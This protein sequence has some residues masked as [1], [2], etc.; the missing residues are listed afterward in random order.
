M[1][2]RK[3]VYQAGLAH[4]GG[5]VPLHSH[6]CL[7]VRVLTSD[8]PVLAKRQGYISDFVLSIEEPKLT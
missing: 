4:S 3:E 1:S 2:G 8:I 5:Q 6:H 7:T